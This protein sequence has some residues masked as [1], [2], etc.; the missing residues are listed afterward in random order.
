M[1]INDAD[2]TSIG[3]FTYQPL[4]K[5]ST[6]RVLILEP[7]I[8]DMPLTGELRHVDISQYRNEE[9]RP[10]QLSTRL[11]SFGHSLIPKDPLRYEALSYV[12][13]EPVYSHS[14]RCPKGRIAITSN[15]E[16]A[17]LHIRFPDR[18]RVIWVD[19]ICINQRDLQERSQQ[20]RLMGDVYRSAEQVLVWLGPDHTQVTARRTFDALREL[21]RPPRLEGDDQRIHHHLEEVTKSKWFTR[22]WVVQELFLARRAIALW[23]HE[24][25][26][27][28]YFR[29]PWNKWFEKN[30]HDFP[31]WCARRSWRFQDA[32]VL[33]S[34]LHCSDPRDRVYALLNLYQ[35]HENESAFQNELRHLTPD[36]SKPVNE[37]FRDMAHLFVRCDEVQR[38][39]SQINHSSAINSEVNTLPS[40]VPDWG[41]SVHQD[42]L[43]SAWRCGFGSVSAA[44][45]FCVP[46]VDTESWTLTLKGFSH[47]EIRYTPSND[48]LSTDVTEA[49][50]ESV[51]FWFIVVKPHELDY[52]KDAYA[53]LEESFFQTLTFSNRTY[54]ERRPW[55]DLALQLI[56]IMKRPNAGSEDMSTLAWKISRLIV[57]SSGAFNVDAGSLERGYQTCERYWRNR[58]LFV[59]SRGRIG[60]GP[61]ITRRGDTLAVFSGFSNPAIICKNGGLH[62]FVGMAY[63]PSISDGEAVVEWKGSGA[64]I[65]TF[66]LQ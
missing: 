30:S 40:W 8:G 24:E 19:A 5:P 16:E 1:S 54:S 63:V 31:R 38:L 60:L 35:L 41:Y 29:A 34:N 4:K 17:L 52:A 7:G 57:S 56:G 21:I 2:K 22:L 14:L 51:R 23:G 18:R 9:N 37:V 27:F 46:K 26:D 50:K 47:D 33:T 6:I 61:S 28:I 62:H 64:Q 44:L 20:V 43:L 55:N 11:R 49:I 58:K 36:Y 66:E 32:L 53:S 42:P 65:E 10:V 12:W 45:A 48:L 39:L 59:T 25:I 3:D 15:L 13:G